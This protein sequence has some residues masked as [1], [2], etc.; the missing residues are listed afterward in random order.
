MFYE[1]DQV[2]MEVQDGD[3]GQLADLLI[4]D[5]LVLVEQKKNEHLVSRNLKLV[6]C[7]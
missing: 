5:L 3:L 2:Q 4:G 1:R 7:L 6:P